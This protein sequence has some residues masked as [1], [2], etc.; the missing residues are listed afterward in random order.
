MSQ[1]YQ[2]TQKLHP[3]SPFPDIKVTLTDGSTRPLAQANTDDRWQL[4]LIYRGR[5]CPLCTRYLNELE[6]FKNKLADIK[7]DIVAVSGDS[8]A[9]LQSH[10]EQLNVSFTL[11][12]GLSLEEM[13]TLGLFI[14]D[15]RSAQET[16]HPFAEPGLFVVNQQGNIQV[17]DISNNPFVR[18]DLTSLVN[19]LAWIRDP[20]NNYP[21]RGMHK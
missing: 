15:P 13:Q 5:H 12:Y 14:S 8:L 21:I 9:Q 2:N 18:P 10:S 6:Q 3:G 20:D 17:T 19:G 4:V 11:G 16:D 1:A 7:V